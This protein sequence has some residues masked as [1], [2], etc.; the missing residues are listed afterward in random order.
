MLLWLLAISATWLG[1]SNTVREIVKELPI[2]RRERGVGLSISAYLG[3]KAAVFGAITTVQAIVL[4]FIALFRQTLPVQD[5]AHI[6]TN[7]Q[8]PDTYQNISLGINPLAGL[9]PFD[10]G[11]VLPSQLVEILIAVVLSGLAGMALGLA[12]SARVRR[13]DQAILLLPIVLVVQTVLSL[14]LVQS[15]VPSVYLTA[16]GDLTSANW[17][18]AAEASTTSLNQLQYVYFANNYTGEVVVANHLNHLDPHIQGF[19]PKYLPG[20]LEKYAVGDTAWR[21]APVPWLLA[22]GLLIGFTA[23]FLGFAWYSLRRLDIGRSGSRAGAASYV[24]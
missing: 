6:L 16:L 10:S 18:V 11:S 17:G 14:P 2:Y 23:L 15:Q 24:E 7:L 9:R 22:I 8:H 20:Q 19:G 13:S 5:T 1:A 12:I 3:S 21:H 4:T